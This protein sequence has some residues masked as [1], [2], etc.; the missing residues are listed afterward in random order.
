M[1]PLVK[2]K[3]APQ[4]LQVNLLGAHRQVARAHPFTGDRQQSRTGFQAPCHW[5]TLGDMRL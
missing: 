2:G 5:G 3:I 4:P 1:L